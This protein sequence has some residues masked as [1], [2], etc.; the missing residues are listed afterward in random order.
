MP[1][2]EHCIRALRLGVR[3][4]VIVPD[5][6]LFDDGRGKALRQRLM[7]WCSRAD[8][9]HSSGTPNSDSGLLRFLALAGDEIAGRAKGRAT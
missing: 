8:A 3:A 6:V 1:F 9:H 4:A 7:N 5:N 2:V